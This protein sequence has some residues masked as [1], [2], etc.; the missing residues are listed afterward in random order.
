MG[1]VIIVIVLILCVIFAI[2]SSRKHFKGQ[3][4]CCGGDADNGDKNVEA[5]KMLDHVVMTKIIHIE[6]MHCDNCKNSVE[7]SLN[8]IDGV[9]AQ[10]NLKRKQA[11]VQMNHAVEDE[12]L[13]FAVRRIGFEVTGIETQ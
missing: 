4:G 3:G 11:I 2:Y 7:R 1:T 13:I 10:V 12:T 6:G 9:S 8:H 5:K